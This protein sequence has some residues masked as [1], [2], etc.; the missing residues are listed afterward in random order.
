MHLVGAAA[1]SVV[2]VLIVVV[3][4]VVVALLHLPMHVWASAREQPD[5]TTT[6]LASNNQQMTKYE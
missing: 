4:A 3:D 2:I 1:R 6:E 5:E